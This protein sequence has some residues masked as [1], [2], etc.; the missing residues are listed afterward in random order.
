MIKKFHAA[1]VLVLLVSL[2]I[3]FQLKNEPLPTGF[4]IVVK[5]IEGFKNG[6]CR[7][8]EQYP[9]LTLMCGTVI[10]TVYARLVWVNHTYERILLR[11][12]GFARRNGVDKV[13]T[14]RVLTSVT[15]LMAFLVYEMQSIA[16]LIFLSSVFVCLVCLVVVTYGNDTSGFTEGVWYCFFAS[17]AAFALQNFFYHA[18]A[19]L[20]VSGIA[21][22]AK[23][24]QG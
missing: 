8:C 7:L 9:N 6:M 5:K 18:L 20:C 14:R 23:H 17:A 22:A 11:C 2:F 3:L 21:V 24:I 1:L 12:V 10:I 4:D 13:I 15:G 19:C 16:S